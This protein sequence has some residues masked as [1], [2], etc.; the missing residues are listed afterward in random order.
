M[1]GELSDA[2]S[3]ST[4]SPGSE[5]SRAARVHIPDDSSAG[6]PPGEYHEEYPDHYPEMHMGVYPDAQ[7]E[8]DEDWPDPED[9]HVWQRVTPETTY[10]PF[11]KY[12]LNPDP[13]LWGWIPAVHWVISHE[14]YVDVFGRVVQWTDSSIAPETGGYT[15]AV[16]DPIEPYWPDESD[17]MEDAVEDEEAAPHTRDYSGGVAAPPRRASSCPPNPAAGVSTFED[18]RRAAPESAGG[19]PARMTA[20]QAA[21]GFNPP[22]AG[23]LVTPPTC[24][25]PHRRD[26]PRRPLQQR[27]PGRDMDNQHSP[28]FIRARQQSQRRFPQR[29]HQEHHVH[30]L[31]H[32]ITHQCQERQRSRG[33]RRLRV[34]VGGPHYS[35]RRPLRRQQLPQGVLPELALQSD[36][37]LEQLEELFERLVVASPLRDL[38]HQ[39]PQQ[40]RQHPTPV[41]VSG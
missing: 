13:Q 18:R 15:D 32:Y 14:E 5:L 41:P 29:W 19:S 24:W 6:Y 21:T 10:F 8:M 27:V 7:P 16:G 4:R 37:L 38:R 12:M 33:P 34:V 30:L 39:W 35:G 20:E 26:G 9:F 1:S 17:D 31:D 28:I 36:N 25:D 11:Q 23:G 40:W 3:G 2:G 22:G